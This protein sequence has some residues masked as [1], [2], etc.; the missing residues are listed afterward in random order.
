[1]TNTLFLLAALLISATSHA[2][3]ASAV[4]KRLANASA[5]S[6]QALPGE[7]ELIQALKE[8][9]KKHSLE[10]E[11]TPR[12]IRRTVQKFQAQPSKTAADFADDVYAQQVRVIDHGFDI[13]GK[14]HTQ[15]I[16]VKEDF[17]WKVFS[18]D[19]VKMREA[20]FD[21][22]FL[23]SERTVWNNQI[24]YDP[25]FRH[26]IEFFTRKN[27]APEDLG[28]SLLTRVLKLDF[29]DTVLKSVDRNQQ[30]PI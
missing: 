15:I 21:K 3:P 26:R 14:K 20:V 11:I 19:N 1:M 4:A 29:F 24:P 8:M 22:I 10:G 16:A 18:M 12:F 9:V 7:K 5:R 13:F 27:I 2:G 28:A 23:S 25:T 6:S 17:F 30:F